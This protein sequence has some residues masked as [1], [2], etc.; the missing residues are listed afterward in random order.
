MDART[1]D[2]ILSCE[3]LPSLPAVALRVIELTRDTNVALDE[4]G[5]T[6]QNDQGLAS[7]V[8]KTVNSS[9]YGLRSKCS[10]IQRAL[11]MLGLKPVKSLALGFSIVSAV[12]TDEDEAFDYQAY[13]RRGLFSA[14]AAKLLAEAAGE[15]EHADEAFLGGLLQDIGQVAMYRAL[16]GDYVQALH[17]ALGDHRKLV[18]AEL[19]AFEIQHPDIGAMLCERW[20]LPPD[21][22]LP[23]RYHERPTAAPDECRIN[24]R[25]VAV[26]NILH[27]VL[28]DSD[29]TA[30][31]RQA[32]ARCDK[33]FGLDQNAVDDL[34][35][36]LGEG[37]AELTQLFKLDT[38]TRAD[39]E[40][41][42]DQAAS[43]ARD[44]ASGAG[45]AETDPLT[46]VYNKIGYDTIMRQTFARASSH[47]SPMAILIVALDG[48]KEICGLGGE[49][50]D[51]E[52]GMNVSSMLRRHFDAIPGT[53][54]RIGR[55]T[56]AVVTE[57]ATADMA[58]N[59]AERF[60]AELETYSQQWDVSDFPGT[61]RLTASIGIAPASSDDIASLSSASHLTAAAVRAA[62]AARSQGGNRVVAWE[63]AA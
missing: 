45:T 38:G 30:A 50:I 44:A 19:D 41:A 11:V 43:D 58:E 33:W 57:I 27:D 28:T 49:A 46:G 13:W 60:R 37:V 4:L 3:D 35:R 7:K 42:L 39:A 53:V 15:H 32:Y 2:K 54:C 5:E 31:L 55:D 29:P 14:A 12:G 36:K 26:G 6:I 9:F 62:Q 10:T 63:R 48:M 61:L 34:V 17:A 16:R 8:L 20:K 24:V 23:V 21:L 40:A 1:L 52:I 51:G 25:C 47:A 22:V 59:V 56:F 18:Q